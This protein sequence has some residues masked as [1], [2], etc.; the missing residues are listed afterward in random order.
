MLAGIGVSVLAAP[1]QHLLKISISTFLS[2][3]ALPGVVGDAGE[4]CNNRE[5]AATGM[6]ACC[7]QTDHR[8]QELDACLKNGVQAVLVFPC[9][10]EVVQ[11]FLIRAFL[12]KPHAPPEH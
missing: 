3:A 2:Y 1:A 6:C 8:E 5:R 10:S 11:Q 9:G 4:R 12:I 7:E